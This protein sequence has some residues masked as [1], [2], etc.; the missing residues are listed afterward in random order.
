VIILL[1][2]GF[3][4]ATGITLLLVAVLLTA[5]EL[6]FGDIVSAV[7]TFIVGDVL[8]IAVTTPLLLRF[9]RQWR[10]QTLRVP[11]ARIPEVALFVAVI[12]IALWLIARTESADGYRLFYLF[13]LPVVF[14]AVRHGLDGACLA[15]A[16][17]QFGLVGLLQHH[18][19][20]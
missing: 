19:Y 4:G 20:D 11:T 9:A 16:A 15:L 14:T 17:T 13:F 7:P 18:G 6:G 5:G 10:E 2:A 8:G 3:V 1:G 12:I